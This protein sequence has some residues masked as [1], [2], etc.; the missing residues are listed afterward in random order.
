MQKFRAWDKVKQAMCSVEAIDY[1]NN[2]IYPFYRKTVRKYIPFDEAV[3]MESTTMFDKNDVEIFEADV[4]K[5]RHTIY[6]DF[7]F[8]KVTKSRG[9][10][11]RIGNRLRSS[12]LWLRNEDCEVVGNVWE[13]PELLERVEE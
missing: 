5:M 4:V 7:E 3:P 2:K 12:E 9:G 10:C 13:N 8:F 11:W 6:D 1:V